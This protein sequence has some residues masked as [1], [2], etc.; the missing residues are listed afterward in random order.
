MGHISKHDP[1]IGPDED[2]D[3][4]G[5]PRQ[6]IV[7]AANQPMPKTTG[8]ASVFGSPGTKPRRATRSLPPPLDIDS[9]AIRT[10][11]PLPPPLRSER[12]VNRYEQLFQRM[13][14]GSMVELPERN[15][16]AF[17]A[18]AK[19]T[20]RQGHLARRK[21]RDGFAGVWRVTP[22]TPSTAAKKA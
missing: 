3:D 2:D 7:P 9:V 12:G 18:W 19:N 4:D 6:R 5:K 20:E 11:V 15:A 14:V 16:S 22:S 21:L 1:A 13:P 8:L 10:D 17:M